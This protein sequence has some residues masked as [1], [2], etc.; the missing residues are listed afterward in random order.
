MIL[1]GEEG[2]VMA[3]VCISIL[4][5]GFSV[6][7]FSRILESEI[8]SKIL[9]HRADVLADAAV[10]GS[11]QAGLENAEVRIGD[12]RFGDDFRG[13]RSFVVRRA[14]FEGGVKII[15]VRVW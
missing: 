15:E 14:F 8:S 1:P 4:M 10:K 7:S 11:L 13:G 2:L 5:V 12:D 3:L 6:V 9:L